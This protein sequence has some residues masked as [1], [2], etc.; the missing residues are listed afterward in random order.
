[1][2][3][4]HLVTLTDEALLSVDRGQTSVWLLVFSAG[5]AAVSRGIRGLRGGG[6]GSGGCEECLH[7]HV[8]FDGGGFPTAIR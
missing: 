6:D 5:L 8:F 1:M 3:W 4:E 7:H 2:G